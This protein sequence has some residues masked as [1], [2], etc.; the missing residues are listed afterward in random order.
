M[1]NR[2]S[3]IFGGL[4]KPETPPPALPHRVSIRQRRLQQWQRARLRPEGVLRYLE[5]MKAE[6]QGSQAMPWAHSK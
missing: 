2:L 1:K 6:W 5:K 4:K 3:T